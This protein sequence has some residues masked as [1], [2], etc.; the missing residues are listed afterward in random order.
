[1]ALLGGR[2]ILLR[3]IL[4]GSLINSLS[5]YTLCVFNVR[6]LE[7][8]L[9]YVLDV[10]VCERVSTPSLWRRLVSRYVAMVRFTV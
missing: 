10:Y 6:G 3:G 5:E 7:V 1:M 2:S 8:P 9:L 4:P